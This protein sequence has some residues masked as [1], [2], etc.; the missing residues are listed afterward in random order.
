M[1]SGDEKAKSSTVSQPKQHASEQRLGL[2]DRTDSLPVGLMKEMG[3]SDAGDCC[4]TGPLVV[5][6]ET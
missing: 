5:R 1:A 2:V 4:M 3:S 6:A